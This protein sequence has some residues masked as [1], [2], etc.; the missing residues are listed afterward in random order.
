MSPAWRDPLKALGEKDILCR[1]DNVVGKSGIAFR[2]NNT[3]AHLLL[4][5]SSQNK[6][7]S[8]RR[9]LEKLSTLHYHIR[10]IIRIAW[11]RRLSPF[12]EG[13]FSVV[14]VSAVRG[15]IFI[16]FF[17]QKDLPIVFFRGSRWRL[18]GIQTATGAAESESGRRG[19]ILKKGTAL[20]LSVKTKFHAECALLAYHLQHPKINPYRYF[21]GSKLSCHGCGTLFSSFNLVAES[22]GLPQ[23]FRKGS[24]NKTYLRWPWPS[25]LSQEQRMRL[26]PT[27]LSLDKK[28][29]D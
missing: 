12:R 5:G 18:I 7:S 11:S 2:I 26:L 23:F 22:S 27:D 13:Q 6:L 1:W 19:N 9:L 29:N 25:L 28:R 4:L 3:I 20:E 14:S 8:L 16:K 17:P 21:G 15:D 24:H 10:T